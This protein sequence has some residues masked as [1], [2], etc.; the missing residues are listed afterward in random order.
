MQAATAALAADSE[1]RIAQADAMKAACAPIPPNE[2][3]TAITDY[4]RAAWSAAMTDAAD[5]MQAE[6]ANLPP[7]ETPHRRP[8]HQLD[9]Q[10]PNQPRTA[11]SKFIRGGT[12]PRYESCD[13]II[14]GL[15][16]SP[17]R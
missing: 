8:T 9:R 13:R 1:R 16:T 6:M 7:S 11:C 4:F 12:P 15:K 17:A 5:E 2:K 10:R 3:P 14:Y